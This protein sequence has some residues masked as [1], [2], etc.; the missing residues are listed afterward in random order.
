MKTSRKKDHPAIDLIVNRHSPRAMSGEK[1]AKEE[2]NTLF[3]AARWA[4][5]SY[6]GQPWRLIYSE[7]DDEYWEKFMELLVEKNRSWAVNAGA[8]IIVCSRKNFEHNGKFSRTHSFDAGSAWENLALQAS[9]MNIVSHAMAGFDYN[10]AAETAGIP[11][12]YSV[13]A[14]IAVGKPGDPENL[15]E[16][17]RGAEKPSDRKA[18]SEISFKGKFPEF[19]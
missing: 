5:S 3:E 13:E 8:L 14:M 4:P 16:D 9:S 11:E 19:S 6:N 18:V 7:R 10:K 1:L 12:D 15:P 2:L 17:L